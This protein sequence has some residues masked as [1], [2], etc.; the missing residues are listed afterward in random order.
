MLT[1]TDGTGDG[2][3]A[4]VAKMVAGEIEGGKGGLWRRE[5]RAELGRRLASVS[6][7]DEDSVGTI[8]V[9]SSKYPPWLK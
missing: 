9:A 1:T 7:G 6:G 4:A 2:R 5:Q 8:A 3:G